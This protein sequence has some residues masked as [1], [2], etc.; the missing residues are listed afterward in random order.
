MYDSAMFSFAGGGYMEWIKQNTSAWL[1]DSAAQSITRIDTVLS[2]GVN[3]TLFSTQ[4][5]LTIKDGGRQLKMEKTMMWRYSR[6]QWKII[7]EKE[8]VLQ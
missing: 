1:K 8:Q 2:A 5:G 6:G 4:A 7:R 3:D